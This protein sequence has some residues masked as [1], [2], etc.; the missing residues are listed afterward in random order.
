MS[1]VDAPSRQVAPFGAKWRPQ[2]VWFPDIPL[3]RRA[4]LCASTTAGWQVVS[5]PWE[6]REGKKEDERHQNRNQMIELDT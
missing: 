1:L 5:W 3:L 2:A 4:Q 6:K